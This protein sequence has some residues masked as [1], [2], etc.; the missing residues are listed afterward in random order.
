MR[1]GAAYLCAWDLGLTDVR[2]K[3][4]MGR[5]AEAGAA[6]RAAGGHWWRASPATGG[7]WPQLGDHA[8]HLGERL[9]RERLEALEHEAPPRPAVRSLPRRGAGLESAREGADTEPSSSRATRARC[10]RAASSS[11]CPA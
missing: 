3:S 6:A 9:L 4:E 10:S 7:R 5:G 8:A 1:A 11:A 2:P